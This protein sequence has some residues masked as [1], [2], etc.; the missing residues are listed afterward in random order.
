MLTFLEYF[1]WFA[2]LALGILLNLTIVFFF[3]LNWYADYVALRTTKQAADLIE[4]G[5]EECRR[6][7]ESTITINLQG[8]LDAEAEEDPVE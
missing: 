1:T 8:I 7:G 6:T 3:L 2:W 4:E 5:L